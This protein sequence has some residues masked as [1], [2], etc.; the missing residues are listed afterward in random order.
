MQQA[1]YGAVD[2]GSAQGQAPREALRLQ[3]V[4]GLG[5]A[6]PTM[7]IARKNQT[8][9][10]FYA[11]L[12]HNSSFHAVPRAAAGWQEHKK[13]PEQVL[14][15]ESGYQRLT[16][17]LAYHPGASTARFRATCLEH[18]S[19]IFDSDGYFDRSK[20]TWAARP[21][22]T[23]RPGLWRESDPILSRRS[24]Y[25]YLFEWRG[26]PK[27]QGSRIGLPQYLQQIAHDL[28]DELLPCPCGTEGCRLPTME[29]YADL[30]SPPASSPSSSSSSS[31]PA[32]SAPAASAASAA[33]AHRHSS[34]AAESRR[35]HAAGGDINPRRASRPRR[36]HL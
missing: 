22:E 29:E 13:S 11:D 30:M 32:S 36:Y 34:A 17:V 8:D 19:Y 4:E 23:V 24:A 33:S 2:A 35:R 26:V 27:A 31:A 12:A 18:A 7:Y 6:D 15:G 25:R 1:T 21:G 14:N 16:R 3:N 5:D 28:G 10:E 9:S 20:Y